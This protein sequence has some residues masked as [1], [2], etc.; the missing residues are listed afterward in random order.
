MLNYFFGIAEAVREL[1]KAE[2][3]RDIARLKADVRK[4]KSQ[5]EYFEQLYINEKRKRSYRYC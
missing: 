1:E 5:A 2:Y 3:E 4:W